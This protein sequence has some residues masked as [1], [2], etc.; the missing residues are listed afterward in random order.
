[1]VD[2]GGTL[3]KVATKLRGP[4]RCGWS[5]RAYTGPSGQRHGPDGAVE[6]EELI[7]TDSDPEPSAG[8][9]ADHGASPSLTRR[10]WEAIRRNHMGE[11]ISEH[12][13]SREV[14]ND[15]E[16]ANDCGV[17]ETFGNIK[18]TRDTRRGRS[19]RPSGGFRGL[20]IVIEK[21]GTD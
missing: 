19:T 1:M 6:I 12:M 3:T 17:G 21:H 13:I 10:S 15:Y 7:I 4:R 5:R 9:L 11:S 18:E 2:T 8:G 20:E 16:T 14:R